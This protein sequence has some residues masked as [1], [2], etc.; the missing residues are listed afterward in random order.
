MISLS[1]SQ[2]IYFWICFSL[3]L[4]VFSGCFSLPQK[5]LL[6]VHESPWALIE[7]TSS[8]CHDCQHIH[9][10]VQDLKT[11]YTGQL[12][13]L[14]LDLSSKA[15]RLESI[16]QAKSLNGQEFVIKNQESPGMV[17][18]L[19]RQDG[20]VKFLFEHQADKAEYFKQID[21][22]LSPFKG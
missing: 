4:V 17:A 21:Q 12:M 15:S 10:V 5:P 14:T 6:K 9:E 11:K 20:Y 13:T 2:K 3:I 18:L 8:D 19:N 7:L 1:G 16:H 22:V